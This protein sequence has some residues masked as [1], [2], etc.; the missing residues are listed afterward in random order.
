MYFCLWNLESWALESG[1]QPKWNNA[2]PTK[3]WD[4]ESKP[5]NWEMNPD[6]VQ[7]LDC[8]ISM[9]IQNP[10]ARSIQ[11][12]LQPVRPGKVVHLKRWTR[13]FET[14]PVG[15]NRSIEFWTE[16]SGNFGWMDRARKTTLD[17]LTW[18]DNLVPR[19]HSVLRWKVRSPFPLA[20]GELGT[21]LMG[22][23]SLAIFMRGRII[24]PWPF[25]YYIQ[26]HY[27]SGRTWTNLRL[28]MWR[29]Q[30]ALCMR[31]DESRPERRT[32]D[33]SSGARWT[34]KGLPK[35]VQTDNMSLV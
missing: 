23:L 24:R 1:I 26:S 10:R 12:K 35:F 4:P 29:V 27:P 21:R 17:F 32:T 16:I 28:V 22:W 30:D 33:G 18:G 20:V 8:V 14:F 9:W 19:F 15:P 31:L 6:W 5:V 3:D 7:Y 34:T 11:P 25:S 13:F 2:D